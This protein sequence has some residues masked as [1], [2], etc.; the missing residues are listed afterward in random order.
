MP[1]FRLSKSARQLLASCIQIGL[2]G[3]EG[4]GD[5][6]ALDMEAVGEILDELQES[7]ATETIVHIA[8]TPTYIQEARTQVT[9]AE[10]TIEECETYI[11]P[12]DRARRLADLRGVP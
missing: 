3:A 8:P 2:E 6:G 11:D 7:E 1:I 4:D 5:A 10:D 12:D 9:L